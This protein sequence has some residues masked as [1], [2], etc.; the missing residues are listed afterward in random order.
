MLSKWKK[1][2]KPNRHAVYAVNQAEP[3]VCARSTTTVGYAMDTL[4]TQGQK[5]GGREESTLF[6][7]HGETPS[8]VRKGVLIGGATYGPLLRTLVNDLH[9]STFLNGLMKVSRGVQTTSTGERRWLG[10]M[11]TNFQRQSLLGAIGFSIPENTKVTTLRKN[12]V[13]PLRITT[14]CLKNNAAVVQSA[15]NAT[16]H[17]EGLL[18]IIAMAAKKSEVFYAI[19]ATALLAASKT[20]LNFSKVLLLTSRGER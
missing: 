5:I 6:L 13:S 20:I 7:G 11:K 12:T 16:A 14:V 19:F 10:L 3:V 1:Q 8:S 18:S 9:L 4:K 2:T 17:S 15:G